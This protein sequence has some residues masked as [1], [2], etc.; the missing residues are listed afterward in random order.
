[1]IKLHILLLF[2]VQEAKPA[3]NVLSEHRSWCP[4]ISDGACSYLD[5][6]LKEISPEKFVPGW[7]V[8]LEILLPKEADHLMVRSASSSLK[9]LT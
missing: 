9:S 7:K 5:E 6:D 2:R 8:L 3:L 4:W 1:M